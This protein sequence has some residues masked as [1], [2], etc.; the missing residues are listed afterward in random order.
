[1]CVC[2]CVCVCIYC[3]INAFKPYDKNNNKSIHKVVNKYMYAWY[4]SI[5]HVCSLKQYIYNETCVWYIVDTWYQ[6][7]SIKYK[8]K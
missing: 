4:V 3:I 2:V 1:M 5:L 7:M 6:Y 8:I